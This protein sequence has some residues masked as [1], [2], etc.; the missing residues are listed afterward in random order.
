MT[1]YN[2][3]NEVHFIIR[4]INFTGVAKILSE[5]PKDEIERNMKELCWFQ[6]RPL[7]HLIEERVPV[8]RATKAD[9]VMWLDR[10][11]AIFRHTSPQKNQINDTHPCTVAANEVRIVFV[12]FPIYRCGAQLN[13]NF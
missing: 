11:S 10:L 13:L 6:A 8:Q 1:L 12:S 7:C 9:P 2:S 3:C 4:A 5:L